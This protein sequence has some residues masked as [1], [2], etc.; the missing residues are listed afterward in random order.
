VTLVFCGDGPLEQQCREQVAASGIDNQVRFAGWIDY[1]RMPGVLSAASVVVLASE[2]EGLS[3]ALLEAMASERCVVA[4]D[5]PASREVIG[6]GE[7]GLLFGIGNPA[8]LATKLLT[9]LG[10][11]ELRARLGQAARASTAW[12]S[13]ESGVGIHIDAM[14]D[15]IAR[16]RERTGPC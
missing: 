8:D 12:R 15:A 7:N 6:D 2:S 14:Q 11:G 4:S 13:I 3:R 10:D 9:A 5:I 16:F 1:G